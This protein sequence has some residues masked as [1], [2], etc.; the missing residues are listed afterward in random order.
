M[1][2]FPFH[3]VLHGEE[4]LHMVHPSIKENTKYYVELELLDVIDRGHG[5]GIFMVNRLSG[6][7]LKEKG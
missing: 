1:P 2:K 4:R 3:T 7:E 5:K 6:Y